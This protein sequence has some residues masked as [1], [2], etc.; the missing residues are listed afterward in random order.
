[1]QALI[2]ERERQQRARLERA[3]LNQQ[4]ARSGARPTRRPG[5]SKEL[6]KAVFERDGGRCVKCGSTFDLQ[7]YRII[8]FDLGGATT[9][10][11]LQLLCSSCNQSKGASFLTPSGIK[12]LVARTVTIGPRYGAWTVTRRTSVSACMAASRSFVLQD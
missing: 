12:R 6:K 9:L 4:L 1:M 11:N 5:L 2:A 10:G 8:P 3:H 7:Y